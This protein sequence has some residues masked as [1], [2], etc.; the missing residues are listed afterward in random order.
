MELIK[1]LF[2]NKRIKV[3]PLLWNKTPQRMYVAQTAFG[4]YRI[5]FDKTGAKGMYNLELSTKPFNYEPLSIFET[6]KEAK[7]YA[8]IDF[9]SRI[10]CSLIL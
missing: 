6:I 2:T 10:K 5:R 4:F 1:K 9:N 7:E 3:K 8:Q